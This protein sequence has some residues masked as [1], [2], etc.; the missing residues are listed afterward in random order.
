MSPLSKRD[1]ECSNKKNQRKVF[2]SE[3]LH[4]N[5]L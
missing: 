4:I 3:T 1:I 2:L 5:K